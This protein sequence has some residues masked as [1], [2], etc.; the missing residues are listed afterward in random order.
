MSVLLESLMFIKL[1]LVKVTTPKAR[2]QALNNGRRM[3]SAYTLI[4]LVL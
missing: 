2:R 4:T 3:S 1:I